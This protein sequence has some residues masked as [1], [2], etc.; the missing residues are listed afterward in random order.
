MVLNTKGSVLLETLVALLSYG[1][2]LS[3][4]LSMIM[5]LYSIPIAPSDTANDLA[6][7][8]LQWQISINNRF[9][10][11]N[12]TYCFD[13]LSEQRCLH[14]KNNRLLMSPGTQI[15]MRGL[16]SMMLFEKNG[17]VYVSGYKN[18]KLVEYYIA[19]LE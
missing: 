18:S 9:Y 17:K 8:Q 19:T 13:Y 2:I 3:L 4:M 11:E 14:C 1:A 12:Q 16:S 5:A 15:I 10:V 6:I 7:K